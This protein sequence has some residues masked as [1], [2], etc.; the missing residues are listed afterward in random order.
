[1]KWKLSIILIVCLCSYS[2][3]N[4]KPDLF[5]T[6]KSGSSFK[7][8]PT[9]YMAKW[10]GGTQFEGGVGLNISQQ[11]S[12]S[13]I[14]GWVH[15]PFYD[16]KDVEHP[17]TFYPIMPL[18]WVLDK[19]GDPS[20]Q[21]NFDLNAII[22]NQL[23]SRWYSKIG[24][25]ITAF[26]RGELNR[27]VEFVVEDE[28]GEHSDWENTQRRIDVEGNGWISPNYS[29]IIGLGRN[30]WRC[31]DFILFSEISFRIPVFNPK[32]EYPANDTWEMPFVIGV[33]F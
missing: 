25:G 33:R 10:R 17:T 30:L 22:G 31:S 8:H 27:L 4:A 16:P 3:L 11:S 6:V 26:R 29:M 20:E 5:Y 24:I 19:W 2:S 28:N 15:Y 1:M 32:T 12:I 9:Y 23:R 13:L 21:I 14:V 18:S 7:M